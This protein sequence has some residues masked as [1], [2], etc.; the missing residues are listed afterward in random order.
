MLPPDGLLE[1]PVC[2]QS[3]ATSGSALMCA[4]GHSFDI[5]RQGYI[6]LLG[7]GARPS[8]ADTA[9]MVAAREA[10]LATGHYRPIADAVSAAV[11]DSL[12]EAEGWILDAGAG[13]GYYLAAV[14]ER[15]GRLDG[16]ALDISKYAARRAV[17]THERMVSVVADTWARVPVVSGGVA[18]V[19]S[20]FAPRNAAEFARVLRPGG[21]LVTV[22]PTRDH[23]RGLIGPLGLVTVEADKHERLTA[24]MRESFDH[25]RERSVELPLRLSHPEVVDLVRMGPSA[26]HTE[27]GE[28][29]ARLAGLPE[30]AETTLSV[31]IAVW[32]RAPA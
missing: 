30:P 13:S 19:M 32:R 15:Y 18:A 11:G 29:R 5:A 16:L 14:L 3:L 27:L 25:E 28:L 20:V 6:N 24:G 8:T 31:T 2:W 17:R 22:I 4:H 23:L 21:V 12:S 7:G 9:E 26:R 1:C 10:F